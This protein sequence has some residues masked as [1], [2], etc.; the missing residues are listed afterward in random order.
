MLSVI[1]HTKNSAKTLKKCLESVLFADE[2]I[3]MDMKS[4]DET[5][6]VAKKY[7][8]RFFTTKD[9]GY[10]EPARNEAISKAK[11][12][13]VFI[14]DADE[15]MAPKLQ[16]LISQ[17]SLD[18]W[19]IG[20]PVAY[21]IA[22]KNIIWGKWMEH[23]GWWPDHQL[24]LFVK[25][26]VEWKDEIHSEP[27]VSGEVKNLPADPSLAILHHNYTSVSDFISRLD[28]YSSIQA[29]EASKSTTLSQTKVVEVFF[30]EFFRRTF[31][32]NG[33]K[34]GTH[35]LAL[36]MM[37]SMSEL[38][39]DLKVWEQQDFKENKQSE[40]EVVDSLHVIQKNMKYW[41]ADWHVKNSSGISKFVW[42]VRRKLK[43]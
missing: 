20:E 32:W 42:K 19:K 25:G 2:I 28:R 23:T 27:K 29:K 26:K 12:D 3:I 38:I 5:L 16:E 7:D 1:I 10:V 18:N 30:D 15:E 31:Q 35:G 8:V 4:S 39:K 43:I 14:L 21:K 11:G 33:I 17:L 36:S 13:W 41:L 22:R 34:D 9:V 40:S 6:K 37:Q 24:R